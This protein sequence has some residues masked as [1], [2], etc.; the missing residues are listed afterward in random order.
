MTSTPPPFDIAVVGTGPVGLTAALALA[1]TG[2]QIALLG[3]AQRPD[4]RH[5]DRRTAALF[6]GSITL[7]R[8]LGVW[9]DV[10]AASAPITAIRMVDSRSAV[11]RAPEVLFSAAE[12]GL[13]QLGYNVPNGALS[14]ALWQRVTANQFVNLTVV[15]TDAVTGVTFN[16]N[17]GAQLTHADGSMTGARIVVGA[18][19]R[20]SVCRK[21]AGIT[22]RSWQYPQTAI[23]CFFDHQRSHDA[24]STEFHSQSGPCTVVPL[25]GQSSSL[26]WVVAPAQANR[27]LELDTTDFAAELEQQLLGLLGAVGNVSARNAFPLSA[28]VADRFAAK[29][30]AIVG[31]AA[32]VIPPIG[33]QGLNLGLRDCAELADCVADAGSAQATLDCDQCLADYDRRRRY[34]VL[35]RTG[36]V[37]LFNRSFLTG[38]LPAHLARGAGLHALKSIAPLRRWAMR[39]G[40][41]PAGATPRL[42]RPNVGL[43]NESSGARSGDL[44]P[45]ASDSS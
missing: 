14:Q 2:R 43:R 5:E 42:M 31:E 12:I 36:A 4:G 25:P 37:D 8:N 45:A 13:P 16:D 3:P 22:T 21:A 28:V 38:F 6:A 34:D 35:S 41:S 9:D 30:V 24:V 18:D 11:L 1:T 23:T 26:V 32:H 19:G 40:L 44:S 39:E 27:L 17:S 15:E 10:S 7:L 29:R 33:A 20:N